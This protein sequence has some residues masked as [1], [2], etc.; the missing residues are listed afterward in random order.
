MTKNRWFQFLKGQKYYF[1]AL[2]L[3]SLLFVIAVGYAYF[4]VTIKAEWSRLAAEEIRHVQIQKAA[5]D[6][7]LIHVDFNMSYLI[8]QV[9]QHFKR[10]DRPENS[11]VSKKFFSEDFLS[12]IQTNNLYKRIRLLNV[13]GMELINVVCNHGNPLILPDSKLQFQG[14]EIYYKRANSFNKNELYIS[15]MQLDTE[16]GGAAEPIIRFAAPVFN[17]GHL[18]AGILALDF[19]ASDLLEEFKLTASPS[20]AAM[21]LN[22]EGYWLSHPDAEKQW[23]FMLESSM[24]MTMAKTEPEVWRQI[25]SASSGQFKDH[26]NLITFD[27]VY[28]LGE[29]AHVPILHSH[30]KRKDYAWKV[31]SYYSESN[32]ESVT[33]NVRDFTLY[34]ALFSML[35][36][37]GL[38]WLLARAWVRRN[39]AEA[40]V[41]KLYNAVTQ[42]SGSIMITDSEGIIEYV[43]PAFTKITGYSAAEAIGQTPRFL[44]SGR[45]DAAYYENMWETISHGNNWQDK[46]IDRNKDGSLFPAIL[47]IAPIIDSDGKITHYVGSHTDVSELQDMEKQ[48]Q[49]AQKMEAIGTLVG[50]IAHDFN[51]MLAGITGNIY[52]AK[53]DVEDNAKAFQRLESIEQLSFRAADMIKQLLTF[54]RKDTVNM[55]PI[56]LTSYIKETIKFLRVS[57]PE[58]IVVH[59]NIC[60]NALHVNGDSTQ[61]HQVLMNLMTNARDAVENVNEPCIAIKLEA[62]RPGDAFLTDHVYFKACN[63]AHLSV[64]DNGYGIPTDKIDHLFEPFFTTKDQGKGTGLGLAMVFGAMKTHKGF[65]EVES[66]EGEGSTFHIYVPL[67]EQ[68]DTALRTQQR[69]ESID[70]HGELILFADDELHVRDTTAEILKSMGYKV[71]TAK[72]GIEALEVFKIH[73]DEIALAVLDVVMPHCGGVQLAEL[74]R[75]INPDL[76]VIFVTG[77][78][79]MNMLNGRE[80]I[81]DSEVISKPVGYG[82]L[83]HTMRKLLDKPKE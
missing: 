35:L 79:K 2:S 4:L 47:S 31:V 83:S 15:P 6:Q 60:D 10:Y 53:R 30:E 26:G 9:E 61:I 42:S 37:L 19:R 57:I 3:A 51:N 71:L 25:Q 66:I 48:F 75:E 28:P 41:H 49:Q 38:S 70:G 11:Q 54:A 40:S 8:N 63:Y 7:S 56:P 55:T 5:L 82:L 50:G 32:L 62:F 33:Y 64:E 27:T 1:V 58:N 16:E 20:T 74:I 46:V 45:Q 21:L 29:L 13:N 72:D 36:L 23:G 76:P 80:K 14:D 77:Y 43:N 17:G 22:S 73:Q 44:K 78:D 24:A 81:C 34:V 52:L 68:E 59:Q 39:K 12:F 65:V 18:K 69:V 67:L